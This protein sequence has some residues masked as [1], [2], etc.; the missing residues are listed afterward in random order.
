MLF[1]VKITSKSNI[2]K[3]LLTSLLGIIF[4]VCLCFGLAA[5]KVGGDTPRPTNLKPKIYLAG[6]STVKTYEDNQFIAGWGQY[7]PKFLTGDIQIVNCA[8]GGRSSRSFINEGR[9]YA[10]EGAKYSSKAIENNI[11]KGDFLFIQFGHNDDETG[12]NTANKY[13]RWV[14]LGEPDSNGIYPVTAGERYAATEGSDY[15]A[16]YYPYGSGTYKWF[17]KQYIDFARQKGAIPVL[18]TPVS[19]VKYSGNEIVGGAGRFGDGFAYIKAVRQLA[20]EENC[21]LIDLFAETKAMLEAATKDYGSYLMALKPNSLTG[22]WPEDYDAAYDEAKSAGNVESTH[23]NKYGAYLTAAK[24]AESVLDST[25]K[26][27]VKRNNEYYTFADYVLKSPV[28]DV[29]PSTLFGAAAE[30]N[31][32]KLFKLVNPVKQTGNESGYEEVTSIF[33]YSAAKEILGGTGSAYQINETS[34]FGRFTVEGKGSSKNGAYLNDATSLNTQGKDI[35][36]VLNGVTNSVS[37]K[38]TGK[39]S[40][41]CTLSLVKNGTVI[42][43]WDALASGDSLTVNETELEAATY[44]IRTKNSGAISGLCITEKLEKSNAVG[45]SVSGAKG[46]FLIG[47]SF[48]SDGLTV[49]LNYENGRKEVLSS[50]YTVNSSAFNN[51]AA[52]KYRITVTYG[53]FTGGYDAFVYTA[54]SLSVYDFSLNNSRVTLP[55]QKVFALGGTFNS[56]NLAVQVKGVCAGAGEET[57]VIPNYTVSSPDL[58]SAG[59]KTVTVSAYGKS[60][61]YS[62]YALNLSGVDK[63]AAT[64]TVNANAAVGVSGNAVT[65]KTL[66]DAVRVFKLLGTSATAVKQINVAA[67]EYCEK[68]EIDLPNVRISGA[69]M[70]STTIVFDALSG[71]TDPSGNINYSTDG[72]ATVSVRATASGFVAENICFKNY[73]NSHALYLESKKITN[74]T[75]AVAMLVQA[76]KCVFTNVKF[77]SYHDTLYDM[78]GRHVYNN[79]HIEGK[80]DYI[81]GYNSTAYFN[82]CTLKT[83]GAGKTEKNGGYVVSTKGCKKDESDSID[84]GYIFYDC[85]FTDDGNVQDGS[86]SLARGWGDYMTV[87]F[88][89]CEMSASYSK[90]EYGNTASP[91][92][93]RYGKMNA[94]PDATRL[95]EYGNIGAGALSYAEGFSGMIDNTCTVLTAAEAAK[96]SD[97]SVIFAKT[98]GKLTYPDAWGITL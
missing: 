91:K 27:E 40:S 12:G 44:I 52:G 72:S 86:V 98:N 17:L 41:G 43:T 26:K 61:Q 62:V 85:T 18:V 77:S 35:T 64:V 94:D 55:V 81:F 80:T 24:V 88:I 76:D 34:V 9:L 8:E 42:K 10:V 93:D 84:Y 33:D 14:P 31:V 58:S 11:K 82:A 53:D 68:V 46:K 67:G 59:E 25:A 60:A 83:I 1:S 30:A 89:N 97:F 70:D 56:D 39:S 37:F 71:K 2:F 28:S 73:Y 66:N 22:A 13:D 4:V 19:R 45:I 51:A 79:C 65:V 54:K 90:E 49:T 3:A 16:Q 38:I 78:S 50:G 6:D 20:Q 48:S 95:F 57:F 7:L 29:K 87:A 69:G 96:Y 23:Y 63:D 75:Q 74:D 92:N 32:L 21:L 5:C 15:G 47:D 36:F